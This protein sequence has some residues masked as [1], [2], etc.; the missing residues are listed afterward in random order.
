M[1]QYGEDLRMGE[2]KHAFVCVPYEELLA[3][4]GDDDCGV[5]VGPSMDPKSLTLCLVVYGLEHAVKTFVGQLSVCPRLQRAWHC[6]F[7]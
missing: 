4:G 6:A 2:M 7:D 3:I 5:S 1:L